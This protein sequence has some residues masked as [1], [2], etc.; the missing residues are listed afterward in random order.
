M[1]WGHDCWLSCEE[2][3]GSGVRVSHTFSVLFYRPGRG[4]VNT[5]GT[6]GFSAHSSWIS[7]ASN[8]CSSLM[9]EEKGHMHKSIVEIFP[10]DKEEVIQGRD[11][12]ELPKR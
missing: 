11:V 8:L 4:Q 1:G 5:S 2:Q 10:S 7:R 3:E 9:P 6:G 12:A